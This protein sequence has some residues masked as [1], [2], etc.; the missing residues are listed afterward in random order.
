MPVISFV[1]NKPSIEV[2]AGVNLMEALLAHQIPVA[3]SCKGDGI[4]GKCRMRI[5][6]GS[7][8]LE[9]PT[10]LE[11]DTLARNQVPPGLRLSC[12]IDI[13]FD[14]QVDTDYW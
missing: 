10:Q 8:N 14:L 5:Q 3:S 12:Q 4:C 2:P 11:T 6:A 9:P 7:E 13:N 1:K